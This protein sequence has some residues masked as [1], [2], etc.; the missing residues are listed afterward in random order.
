[1]VAYGITV[2]APPAFY[3]MFLV[4]LLSFVLIPGSL[5]AIGA[6]LV[7]NFFPRRQKTVLGASACRRSWR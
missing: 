6:I 1:M 4:Y 5:G 3:A 7:A 2:E